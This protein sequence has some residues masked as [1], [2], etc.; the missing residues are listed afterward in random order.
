MKK[1]DFHKEQERIK[2]IIILWVK[3]IY[4]IAFNIYAWFWLIREI[5]FR[6][7]TEFEPYLLWLFTTA[8]MYYFVLENQDVF[9]KSKDKH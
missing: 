3:R 2:P 9:I 5:F 4:V 1:T 8:G 7:T 6:K